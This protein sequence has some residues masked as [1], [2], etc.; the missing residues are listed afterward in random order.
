MKILGQEIARIQTIVT[1][2]PTLTA[3][4][5]SLVTARLLI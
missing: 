5:A 2:L 3:H 4:A 1:R